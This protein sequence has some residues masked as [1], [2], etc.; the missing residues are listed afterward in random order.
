MLDIF[1]HLFIAIFGTLFI[2]QIFPYIYVPISVSFIFI[3][4]EW[5]QNYKKYNK[6]LWPWKWS[7]QKLLE[8][9]IPVAGTFIIFIIFKGI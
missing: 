7:K 1:L 3:G 4:R 8:A 9:F 6:F 5:F 2:Y